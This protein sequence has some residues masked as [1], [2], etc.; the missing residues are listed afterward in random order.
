VSGVLDIYV[1]PDEP[2]PG[3]KY[4]PQILLVYQE[5]IYK[6]TIATGVDG[7][8]IVTVVPDSV[9]VDELVT[10]SFTVSGTSPDT[11]TRIRITIPDEW[12]WTGLS[13]DLSFSGSPFDAV[14]SQ[15]EGNQITLSKVNLINQ[16]TGNATIS[17]LTTPDVD[18]LSVFLFSSAGTGGTLSQIA[19]S[20]A[21]LVGS[22]TSKTIVSIAEIQNNIELWK[23]QQVTIRGVV[24]IGSGI[25]IT[26]RT[27]A[28]VQDASGIG[29]QVFSFDSPDA[30]LI[31]GNLG[32]ITGIIEDYEDSRGDFTTE[33]TDYDLT[34]LQKDVELPIPVV[35]TTDQATNGDLEGAYIEVTGTIIDKFSAGEATNIVLDDG[36]GEVTLR[37]WDTAEIDLSNI[38]V[39]NGIS[40]R[41]VISQF[42]GGGQVLIGYQEDLSFVVVPTTPT[43]LKIPAKPFAPDQGEQLSIT[44][45]AGSENA[46]ITLRIYDL[47]G[48]LITTL[49]DEKGRSFEQRLDW[50]G[51]DRLNEQV[52]VGV[53]IL[54]MEVVNELSGKR[55]EKTAPIVIGTVISR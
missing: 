30:N 5:D 37:V 39:G 43:S 9:G 41:G 45:S 49:I 54:H 24:T 8:G 36:S 42:G 31:R 11:V 14:E 53:Y 4:E 21:I 3:K 22:G 7:S 25:L 28:Y 29:I 33:I 44:Y 19:T 17:N 15:V 40:A 10:L 26:S 13:A 32:L 16:S 2:D 51:T 23:G 50:D 52:P 34:V 46:Y 20:P 38:S 47:G 12:L 55:I 18:T 27:E 6:T 48:R 35:L 1:D